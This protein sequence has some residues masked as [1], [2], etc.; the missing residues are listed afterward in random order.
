MCTGEFVC[1]LHPEESVKCP[2][3]SRTLADVSS[4]TWMGG[5]RF[6]SFARASPFLNPPPFSC[7]SPILLFL[8]LFFIFFPIPSFPL[9]LAVHTN[10]LILF[11]SSCF[12]INYS[13]LNRYLT[14]VRKTSLF[15]LPSSKCQVFYVS[16]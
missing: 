12:Y 7:L 3:A 16:E 14:T 15:S 8:L 4:T 9:T 2:G 11:Y 5:I 1:L 13:N 6:E 10:F